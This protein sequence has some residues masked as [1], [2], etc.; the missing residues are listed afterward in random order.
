VGRREHEI[1]IQM[2]VGADQAAITR[3]VLANTCVLGLVGTLGAAAALLASR[4]VQSALYQTNA[5]NPVI[6]LSTILVLLAVMGVA[7]NVPTRRAVHVDPARAL[8]AE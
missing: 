2:A 6:L 8:R 7:P 5:S 4:A 3:L 1:G